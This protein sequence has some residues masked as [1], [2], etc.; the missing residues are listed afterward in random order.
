[1]N[2]EDFLFGRGARDLDARKEVKVK[3]PISHLI[4]LHGLKLVKG[5]TI[6]DTV[7]EALNQYFEQNLL[8]RGSAHKVPEPQPA[9]AAADE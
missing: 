5:Q 6:T 1:M 7:I 9:S 3:L 4:K 8:E 2:E